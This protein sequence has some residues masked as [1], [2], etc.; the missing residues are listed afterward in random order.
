[1]KKSELIEEIKK[2]EKK[3]DELEYKCILAEDER[4][5]AKVQIPNL[6]LQLRRTERKKIYFEAQKEILDQTIQN[7]ISK[8]IN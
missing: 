8:L 2:L 4:D 5:R 3:V 7:T 6:E 1:L